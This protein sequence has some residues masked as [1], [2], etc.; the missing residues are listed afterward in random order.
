[1]VSSFLTSVSQLSWPFLLTGPSALDPPL[2]GGCT[3]FLGS[4]ALF[5]YTLHPIWNTDDFAGL[6]SGHI[7]GI[8]S[9][10]S[11]WARK[12]WRNGERIVMFTY[13][14]HSD[15]TIP[16]YRKVSSPYP[17]YP[18]ISLNSDSRDNGHSPEVPWPPLTDPS[19]GGLGHSSGTA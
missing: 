17:C 16:Y 14:Q 5:A 4:Y 12:I 19:S 6:R 1:M 2:Y 9:F 3:G 10:T 13:L 7:T 18:S 15:P 8:A 11:P